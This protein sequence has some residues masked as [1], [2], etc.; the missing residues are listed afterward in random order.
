MSVPIRR[1]LSGTDPTPGNIGA[2]PGVRAA[3]AGF[4]SPNPAVAPPAATAPP[5]CPDHDSVRHRSAFAADTLCRLPGHRVGRRKLDFRP[6]ASRIGAAVA[7]IYEV[8]PEFAS[9]TGRGACRP[10][11]VAMLW[12]GGVR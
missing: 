9:W 1:F 10:A 2:N 6:A 8:A 11:P 3:T 12:Q 5:A 7:P 4:P